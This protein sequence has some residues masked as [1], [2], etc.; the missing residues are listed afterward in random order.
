MGVRVQK[1][2]NGSLKRGEI[3][4][5]IREV[6]DGERKDEYKE[7]VVKWAQKAKEAMQEGGSSDKYILE[8]TAKYSSI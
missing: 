6:M 2:Q 3:K 4:R 5:C 7:N 1:E 8:F